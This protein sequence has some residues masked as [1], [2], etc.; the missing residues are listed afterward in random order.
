MAERAKLKMSRDEKVRAL[1]NGDTALRGE[2]INAKLLGMSK[3]VSED[4]VR[5]SFIALPE[6]LLIA[7]VAGGPRPERW[8]RMAETR[9]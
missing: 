1:Q 3:A 6:R 5:V 2:D 7:A 8:I 9:C 4:S